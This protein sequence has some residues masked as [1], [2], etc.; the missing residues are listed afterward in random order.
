MKKGW[1]IIITIVLV[2][3]LLG[4]VSIGVG[5]LTGG[6]WERIYSA[7]DTRYHLTALQE[8]YTHYFYE[9]LDVVR[10]VWSAA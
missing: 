10:G 9:V 3:I 2:A 1:S 5:Y 8:A 6:S 7:L 4:S